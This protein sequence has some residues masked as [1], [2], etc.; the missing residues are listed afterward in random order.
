MTGLSVGEDHD[1]GQFSHFDNVS[2]VVRADRI[3]DLHQVLLV[4]GTV[5]ESVSDTNA[6][7]TPCPRKAAAFCHGEVVYERIGGTGVHHNEHGMGLSHIARPNQSV[8][9][10]VIRT[11][12]YCTTLDIEGQ[13]KANLSAGI[14]FR[15][16]SGSG[17]NST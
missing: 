8:A 2:V 6:A 11:A 16:I 3:R 12:E 4:G 15:F 10:A 1:G 7:I 9:V 13:S 5:R 17:N 14:V